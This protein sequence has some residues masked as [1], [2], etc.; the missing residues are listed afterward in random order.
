MGEPVGE[1]YHVQPPEGIEVNPESHSLNCPNEMIDEHIPMDD[2]IHINADGTMDV[3]LPDGTTFDVQTN[4]LTFLK[5]VCQFKRNSE[6]A[7]PTMNDDGS[8]TV[9]LQPGM[10]YDVDTNSVRLD[11]YWA[12][13]LSPE[14][15]DIGQEGELGYQA[16]SGL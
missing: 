5:E 8:I 15:V 12:N 6:E 7:H 9:N 11:N 1:H 10:A 4:T 2:E 16:S 3:G 14:P 13:E